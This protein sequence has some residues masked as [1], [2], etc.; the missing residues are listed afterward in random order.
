MEGGEGERLRAPSP[1]AGGILR[2]AILSPGCRAAPCMPPP[3]GDIARPMP[4]GWADILL[5][6]FASALVKDMDFGS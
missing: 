3:S 6:R 1:A 2:A 5:M 4:S